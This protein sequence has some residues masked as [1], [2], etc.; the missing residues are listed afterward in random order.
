MCSLCLCVSVVNSMR[1]AEPPSP[2]SLQTPVTSA[3]L[4]AAVF[5]EW[6]EGKETAIAPP[7]SKD[8]SRKAQWVLWTDKTAPGH[9]G[10]TFGASKRPGI[11]H[12]RV[13]FTEALEAGSVLIRGGVQVSVLKP[14]AAYPGDPAEDAQWITAERIRSAEVGNAEAPRE[15]YVLWTLPEKV[16]TRS[17]RFSHSAEVT[18]KEYA[19]WLG[20]AYVLPIRLANMS[21]Q[22]VTI[23][24]ANQGNV[25]KI[26]NE[27]PDP[28]WEQWSNIE[29]TAGQRAQIVSP[30][31]P[32]WLML[33][34]SA[35]VKL[36]GVGLCFAGFADA[37]VQSYD[38]P[39]GI[40][41]REASPDAWKMIKS[42]AGLKNGY[43]ITLPADWLDFGQDISTRALRLR[44]TK[45]LGD[46]GHPHVQGHAKQGKRVWLGELLALQPLDAALLRSALL[47]NAAPQQRPPIAVKFTLPEPGWATLVVDDA[48]GK[49]VRNLLADTFFEKGENTVWWD[50]SDDL[51][52]DLPAAAHG[53]YLIPTQLV[54]PGQ[55][56]VRGLWRKQVDLRYEFGVYNAGITPWETA[57]K[58]GGWLSNHTPPSSV[59]FVPNAPAPQP[60]PAAGRRQG[61]GPGGPLSPT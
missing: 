42:F 27:L 33:V 39:P 2:G 38:G 59:L 55:Y 37:D 31:S 45:S 32:E 52:R 47:P 5:A 23:G 49:R 11:R 7:D 53:V 50:G 15:S 10:L 34:W 22:A 17:L 1:A 6:C 20:G 60:P 3:N 54:A 16:K 4:D 48:G 51:G 36:R 61:A 44:I 14:G 9:S 58:S 12:L 41:P 18:D 26:A 13:G 29:R 56:R 40:H 28:G 57:D 21:P 35:P 25:Q 19:G 43:P 24:S 8:N 46:G 30:E